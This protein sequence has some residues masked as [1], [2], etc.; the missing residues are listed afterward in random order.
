M[1]NVKTIAFV[2]VIVSSFI[3]CGTSGGS[4]DV[5]NFLDGT[6]SNTSEDD[7]SSIV[8]DGNDWIYYDGNKPVSKGTWVS[9]AVPAA[10]ANGTITFT[11]TQVDMGKGLDSLPAKYKKLKTFTIEYSIDSDGNQL[12]ISK[13]QLKAADPAGIWNK[14]EGIYIRDGSSSTSN[15]ASFRK[16][17]SGGSALQTTKQLSTKTTADDPPISYIITG[18]G[19]SFTAVNDGVIIGTANQAITDVIDAIK[20]DANG[21]NVA[22]QFGNGTSLLDIGAAS[23]RFDS[24]ISG[25]WGGIVLSGRIT[26]SASPT[27]DIYSV[28]ITS[29]A[30][31]STYCTPTGGSGS[32]IDNSGTLIIN[33]GTVTANAVNNYGIRN[34]GGTVIINSGN[35]SPIGESIYNDNISGKGGNIAINGGTVQ[36]ATGRA[37]N[38]KSG[39]T[40]TITGGTVTSSS[41]ETIYNSGGTIKI[42]GGTVSG[43]ISGHAIW[44][45][46]GGTVT[47]TGGTVSMVNINGNYAAISNNSGCTVTITGGAVLAP[48]GGRAISNAGDGTVTIISPPAVIIGS[49]SGV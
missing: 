46:G 22:I 5:G 3:A 43:G 38:N 2:A 47:I 18:N 20:T 41:S 35:V 26:S 27:I 11:I 32:A 29:I 34:R 4:K 49:I 36:S 39:C 14:L 33:G 25:I 23:V 44:N 17:T 24:N 45:T 48:G 19:T 30:D 21:A 16:A 40:V 31:I 6:W 7:T 10:G 42:G 28:F 13:K 37:I 9:S 1:K 15:A 8:L 12:T